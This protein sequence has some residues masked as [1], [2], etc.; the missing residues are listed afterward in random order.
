MTQDTAL[1]KPAEMAV[2]FCFESQDPELGGWRY[3][4]RTD[5]DTSVTGWMVMALQTAKMAG[6]EVPATSLELVNDY[7]DKTTFDGIHYGYQ[8]GMEPTLSMTAEALLCR[9]HL[10]WKQDDPRLVAGADYVLKHLPVLEDRD[11]YHW[12]YATQLM[13]HMEGKYWPAWNESF[14]KLLIESQEKKGPEKGSWDPLGAH[15]DRWASLGQ[16][17]RL[18]VTCLSLYMLESYYRHSMPSPADVPKGG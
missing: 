18:Y 8:A 17:G 12:Y 16:G 6:L 9:Q 1:R 13:H 3:S 2:K 10:G 5:S 15:P 14:S 4:P 11:V 7:L